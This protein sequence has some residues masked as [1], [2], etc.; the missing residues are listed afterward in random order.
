[1]CFG[2]LRVE[3]ATMFHQVINFFSENMRVLTDTPIPRPPR[4][5]VVEVISQFI[6]KNQA[7]VFLTGRHLSYRQYA[8]KCDVCV[9]LLS[10][11]FL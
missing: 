6:H 10:L 7:E 4:A 1:M 5:P 2:S 3:T 8:P 11:I 9:T